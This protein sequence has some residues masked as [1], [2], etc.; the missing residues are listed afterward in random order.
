[1]PPSGGSTRYTITRPDSSPTNSPSIV[2]LP[3]VVL[4]PSLRSPTLHPEDR[5][6]LRARVAARPAAALDLVKKVGHRVVEQLGLLEV[7]RVPGI[8]KDDKR[9]RADRPLQEQR[10]LETRV[11]LVTGG[12]QRR[13]VE[14]FHLLAQVP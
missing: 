13:H 14:L 6:R 12:D 10:R 3:F 9:R 1:M 11:V 5:A 4:Q 8:G 2:F 7:E